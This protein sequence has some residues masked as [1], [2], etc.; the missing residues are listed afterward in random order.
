MMDI[1]SMKVAGGVF[2]ARIAG[3]KRRYGSEGVKKIYEYMKNNG[4]CGPSD[5]ENL[6]V[7]DMFPMKDF[8]LFLR[9]IEKIYGKDELKRNSR[10][11]AKKKGVVGMIIKWAGTPEILMK[12]ASEYW[13]EFYNFGRLEGAVVE[14]GH[15]IIKGFDVS[16]VPFFCQDVLTEYFRGVM[17]NIK[18]KNIKVVHTKCVHN[19]DDHCE[20]E[21]TWNK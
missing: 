10:D 19:G 17:E 18:V 1:D 4:Y 12:K 16:P 6:R 3:I 20:W 11:A 8:L 9:G 21:L 13:P 5:L 2:S 15:G 14:E 7:K